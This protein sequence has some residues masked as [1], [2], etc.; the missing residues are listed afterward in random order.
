MIRDSLKSYLCLSATI[1]S[2]L[3][4]VPGRLAIETTDYI[5]MRFE[6]HCRSTRTSYWPNEMDLSCI[7]Q[8][9][10][11]LPTLTSGIIGR[12]NHHSYMSSKN[13]LY[14]DLRSS[15]VRNPPLRRE[16][17]SKIDLPHL[18]ENEWTCSF[19]AKAAFWACVMVQDRIYYFILRQLGWRMM[20][21][22]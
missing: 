16:W 9:S 20:L 7:L 3:L 10:W 14:C 17:L 18:T 15:P 21:Q 13:I 5:W 19:L 2:S 22:F 8:K 1:E 6:S 12:R 4:S 11:C